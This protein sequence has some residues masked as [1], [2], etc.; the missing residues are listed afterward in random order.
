M[1]KRPLSSVATRDKGKTVIT[2]I[3]YSVPD[4]AMLFN[5]TTTPNYFE[6]GLIGQVSAL[7]SWTYTWTLEGG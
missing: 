2:T 5:F 4:R 7:E 1:G 3:K 6:Y